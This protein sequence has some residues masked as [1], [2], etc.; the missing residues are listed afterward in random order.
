VY[1]T[2]VFFWYLNDFDLNNVSVGVNPKQFAVR[3]SVWQ[4]TNGFSERL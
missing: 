1:Q 2:A 4:V 3:K